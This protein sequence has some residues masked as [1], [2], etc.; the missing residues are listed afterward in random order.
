MKESLDQ[1][2]G[3]LIAIKRYRWQMLITAAMICLLGWVGV[4]LMPDRYEATS[5]LLLTNKSMMGP[6][7]K[8]LAAESELTKEMASLMRKTLLSR[9]NLERVIAETDLDLSV[10]SPGER[11]EL[12]RKLGQKIYIK[13]GGRSKI[14]TI[15]Y[16]DTDPV[17][18]K[19]VVQALTN[20]FIE[21]SVGAT[22]KDSYAAQQFLT[23]QIK[24]Y[25][26][27][28]EQAETKL[29]IFK[30]KNVGLMPTE[31]GNY[32][33][34]LNQKLNELQVVELE[35]QESIKR[36]NAIR[37]Q[38]GRSQVAARPQ[39]RGPQSS[40][41]IVKEI[42]KLQS[43]LEDLTS[44][45]TDNYPE[46]VS[47]RERLQGLLEQQS[48][49][50][51]TEM[52]SSADVGFDWRRS[53]ASRDDLRLELGKTEG[54]VAA[55]RVRVKAFSKQVKDMRARVDIMPKVEADLAQ[56]NRDYLI[57]KKTYEG[58]VQRREA[59]MLSDQ[60]E[61]SSNDL[62]F[63]VIEPPVEPTLPTAPDR[64]KLFTL[65]LLAGI[66]VG[67]VLAIA[68]AQINQSITNIN[69]L[70]KATTLSI[71]G[72]VS[73]LPSTGQD[74]SAR[75][76]VAMLGF[77]WSILFLLYGGLII[78]EAR[79]QDVVQLMTKLIGGVA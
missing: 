68:L 29:K 41:V 22:R 27:K 31:G 46:V 33:S 79:H 14:Y 24:E 45:Y 10:N 60:A 17:L 2:G 21:N 54:E 50:P 52:G 51:V 8:G 73:R 3:Y 13:G 32:F 38:L 30:N 49:Y 18:V 7:L 71:L 70:R 23:T 39:A 76:R 5:K 11:E 16:I 20:I 66:G 37:D 44:Q 57:I 48:E 12:V 35:Y 9:P 59:A 67:G 6:L 1:L 74:N 58:L 56:L 42:E 53:L 43:K 4:L 61:A 40:D 26:S 34:Q 55:L 28:L 19:D 15:S 65:V 72:S 63:Q 78:A 69:E 77:A 36:R 62:Q 47:T 64:G 75:R 25:E